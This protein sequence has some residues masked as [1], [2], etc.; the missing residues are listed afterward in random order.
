MRTT[1]TVSIAIVAAGLAVLT[2]PALA[3]T[4]SPNASG[5]REIN[6]NQPPKG[7]I[8]TSSQDPDG[9]S[10]GRGPSTSGAGN[11]MGGTGSA[12]PPPNAEIKQNM[13]PKGSID[14]SS[15]PAPEG[16]TR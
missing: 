2:V 9:P 7:N 4:G 15:S 6:Q 16:R 8:G 3:Q 12:N 14:D 11:Q 1:S 10:R 13:P 5:S